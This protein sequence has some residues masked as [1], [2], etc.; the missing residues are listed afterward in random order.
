ITPTWIFWG[1]AS[2]EGASQF[3]LLI[4]AVLCL[5]YATERRA[6]L[7]AIGSALGSIALIYLDVSFTVLTIVS[8]V[9]LFIRGEFRLLLGYV[10]PFLLGYLVMM[11]QPALLGSGNFLHEAV[12]RLSLLNNAFEHYAV[13]RADLSDLHNGSGQVTDFTF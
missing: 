7:P 10:A 9:Y 8:V 2:F 3:W 5:L 6:M 13:L 12:E 4:A 1:L 11:L